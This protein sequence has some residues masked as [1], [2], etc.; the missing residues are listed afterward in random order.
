[1]FTAEV[2]ADAPAVPSTRNANGQTRQRIGFRT[3]AKFDDHFVKHGREFGDIS[4]SEYLEMAQQ[5]RDAPLSDDII[6]ARQARGNF[7]RFDRRSGA[8][9]AFEEDLV[10]LTFF[11]PD[12]GEDYFRRA[13][14]R[15]T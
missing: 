2:I 12:D 15:K 14:R 13:V 3:N 8:F 4:K 1:V 5:L 6:E 11:R 10:I 7:A 9:M